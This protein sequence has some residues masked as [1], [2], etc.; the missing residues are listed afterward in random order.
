MPWERAG[1]SKSDVV[2]VHRPVG[3]PGVVQLLSASGQLLAERAVD[4]EAPDIVVLN[5]AR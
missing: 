3:S 2:Q 5:T 4:N 1:A